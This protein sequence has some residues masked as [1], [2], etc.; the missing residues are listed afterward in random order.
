M[1]SQ[2]YNHGSMYAC[3]FI[4]QIFNKYIWSSTYFSSKLLT[5]WWVNPR[6]IRWLQKLHI[7]ENTRLS[8]YVYNF[9]R[10]Y[11]CCTLCNG[12]VSLFFNFLL[13]TYCKGVLL[14]KRRLLDVAHEKLP[15]LEQN[16]LI[17]LILPFL[18]HFLI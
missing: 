4:H 18:W 13:R 15:C 12:C 11:R 8:L 1:L 14:S 7:E 16:I 10:Y 9:E 3:Q 17:Y 5:V 6:Q 2:I